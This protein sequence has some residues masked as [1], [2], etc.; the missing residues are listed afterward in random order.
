MLFDSFAAAKKRPGGCT[1]LL[2]L[3]FFFGVI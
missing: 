1:A 2:F 3:V